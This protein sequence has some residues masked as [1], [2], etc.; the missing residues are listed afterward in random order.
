MMPS[1]GAQCVTAYILLN[2]ASVGRNL[3][4]VDT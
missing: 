4:Q 2:V 3:K 1:S